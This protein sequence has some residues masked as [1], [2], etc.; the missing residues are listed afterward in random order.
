MALRVRSGLWSLTMR[1]T[2]RNPD[3]ALKIAL[4]TPG[5]LGGTMVS[6]VFNALAYSDPE[7]A[8]PIRAKA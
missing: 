4:Q 6:G 2:E 1:L 8:L 5:K 3:L 7:S